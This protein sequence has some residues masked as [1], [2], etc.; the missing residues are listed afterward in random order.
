MV[1]WG[2]PNNPPMLLV[3][4]YMDTAATFSL[5]VDELPDTHYFVGFDMPGR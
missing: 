1:A 4:G 2:N 3:H 5:I